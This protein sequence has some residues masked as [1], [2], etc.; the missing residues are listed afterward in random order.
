M[1]WTAS[2]IQLAGTVLFNVNTFR[3]ATL[4]DPSA[5][6]ANRLIWAPDALGSIAF[7]VS[8]AIAFAPE[9]RW[10]RHRHRRDR[11]WAIGALNLLGSVFFGMSAIGAI[12]LTGSDE[13]LRASW[14]NGGTFLGALCFLVGAVLLFPR[15]PFARSP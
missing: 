12:M 3:A 8:S 15:W 14:A 11:S 4:V 5:T 9:V 7:L 1:D 2:A 10:R 13:V 6:E